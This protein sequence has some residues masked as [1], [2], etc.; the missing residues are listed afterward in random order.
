LTGP[1]GTSMMPERISPVE[2]ANETFS[3]RD[4]ASPFCR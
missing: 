3:V 2:P 4:T 1:S